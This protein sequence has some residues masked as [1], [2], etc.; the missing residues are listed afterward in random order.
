MTKNIR[1]LGR[2]ILMQVQSSG[3]I[4]ESATGY[5]LKSALQF[6]NNG[7]RSFLLVLSEG[8]EAAAIEPGDRIFRVYENA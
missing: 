6:L 5:I 7:R 2:V 3:L 1:E 4:I 8:H